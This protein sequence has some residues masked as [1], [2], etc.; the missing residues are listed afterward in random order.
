MKLIEEYINIFS[1][2]YVEIIK[3]RMRWEAEH[4]RVMMESDWPFLSSWN[5]EGWEKNFPDLTKNSER[6]EPGM[7]KLQSTLRLP[8]E[9][10][11][12][13]LIWRIGLTAILFFVYFLDIMERLVATGIKLPVG[14]G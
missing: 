10:S 11:T 4:W 14:L 12:S 7:T 5:P 3:A 13:P 2:E 8:V 9:K 6:M 1:E